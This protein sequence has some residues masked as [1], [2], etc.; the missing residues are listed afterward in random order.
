M[1]G[2]RGPQGPYKPLSALTVADAH[3]RPS[4]AETRFSLASVYPPT[5]PH[6]EYRMFILQ[7]A[8]KKHRCRGDVTA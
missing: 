4:A 2:A 6:C 8:S 7:S 5:A 1:L 3:Q